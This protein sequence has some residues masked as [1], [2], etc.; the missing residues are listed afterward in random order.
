MLRDNLER[1]GP[2]G[3]HMM[4]YHAASHAALGQAAEERELLRQI[5]KALKVGIGFS[6]E[7]WMRRAYHDE[8]RAAP[9]LAVLEKA[10][11]LD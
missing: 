7:G 1:G 2:Y 10:R 4:V 6:V 8:A 9:L 5:N 3:P 11:A